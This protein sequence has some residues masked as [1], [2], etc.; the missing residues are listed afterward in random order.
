MKFFHPFIHGS[1]DLWIM[2]SMLGS[3]LSSGDV[4]MTRTQS[5][6]SEVASMATVSIVE[7]E[8]KHNCL[9]L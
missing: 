3:R 2:G 8:V 9:K 5:L 1:N 7:S 6:S 4:E